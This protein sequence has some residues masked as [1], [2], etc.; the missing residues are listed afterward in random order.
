MPLGMKIDLYITVFER[1]K[2]EQY[3]M[4]TIIYNSSFVIFQPSSNVG[5][6]MCLGKF[7]S[8]VAIP[9]WGK[10]VDSIFDGPIKYMN[11]SAIQRVSFFYT[12]VGNPL[13]EE[14]FTQFNYFCIPFI[15]MSKLRHE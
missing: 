9:A 15:K 11:K 4:Q 7:L 3:K 2:T 8:A 1:C 14:I 10:P 12:G 13:A 6:Q 5:I